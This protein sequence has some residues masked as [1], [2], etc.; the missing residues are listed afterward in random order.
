MA[1][2]IISWK[3]VASNKWI[4]FDTDAIISILAFNSTVILENMKSKK[5][6]FLYIHPVY[7]ELMNTNRATEKLTR[8]KLLL[9]YYFVNVSLNSKHFDLADVIQKSMPLKSTPSPADLYLG[10]VIAK[11]ESNNALLLTANIKDFPMPLFK[12]LGHV[13]LQNDTNIKLSTLLS[14]DKKYLIDF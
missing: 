4:L 6:K 8:S 3:D 5:V 2:E 12:R 10:S 14:V 13:L 7:L 1:K 11:F 9:D